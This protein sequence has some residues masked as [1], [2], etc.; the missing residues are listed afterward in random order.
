MHQEARTQ[1]AVMY[2]LAP[3]VGLRLWVLGQDGREVEALFKTP[4]NLAEQLWCRSG[5]MLEVSDDH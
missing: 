4:L 2:H 1:A 5:A 3:D